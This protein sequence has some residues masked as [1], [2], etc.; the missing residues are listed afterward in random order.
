MDA[1]KLSLKLYARGPIPDPALFTATFHEFIRRK[2]LPELM[3]DVV[4]Y[5]HVHEGPAV[6][7][8][9]HEADYAIDLGEGRAGLFHQRKRAKA[10]GDG[11]FAA[12]LEDSLRRTLDVAAHLEREPRLA[13]LVFA[14]DELLLRIADRLHAPNEPATFEAVE[15]NLRSLAARLWGADTA[16]T[17]ERG[18]GRGLFTAR[19]RGRSEAAR[20]GD[21]AARL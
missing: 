13:G 14:T 5:G 3:I 8:V 6:L 16:V 19:L 9:G 1:S 15:A 11:S 21:L 2:D 17:F 12:T 4:D 20:A 7:F 10:V 18:D